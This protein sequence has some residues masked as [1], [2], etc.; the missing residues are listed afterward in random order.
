MQATNQTLSQNDLQIISYLVSSLKEAQ[1]S[2]AKNLLSFITSAYED[3]WAGT[4]VPANKA[5][6]FYIE[7]WL[8]YM[9]KL[10]N[11][12]AID[13]DDAYSLFNAIIRKSERSYLLPVLA[14]LNDERVKA[15]LAW[16]DQAYSKLQEAGFNCDY[17]PARLYN[18]V[19]H[20]QATENSFETILQEAKE[21]L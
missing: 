8:A 15:N 13:S 21:M 12:V 18:K 4:Y 1:D 7:E 6:N 9:D 3:R 16:L 2:Q 20:G 14:I 19:I 5:I 17:T 10:R 11:H